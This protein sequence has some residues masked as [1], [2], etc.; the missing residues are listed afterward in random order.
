MKGVEDRLKKVLFSVTKEYIRTRRPV[1][2]K[3]VLEVTNLDWSG[4]TIR[5]DMRKLE[6]LGYLYQPHTSAGRIPTD[7]ALRFYLNEILKIRVERLETGFDIDLNPSF[8][9]GDLNTILDVLARILSKA[10]SG[11][12]VMTRPKLSNLRI[13]GIYI[14]PIT[15]DFAV[16]SAVTELGLSSVV[17]VRTGEMNLEAFERLLR[18]FSGKT[19]G[20]VIEALRTFETQ[21]EDLTDA[22]RTMSNVFKLLTI[23]E[24][25]IVRG[26]TE[27]LRE[28][29]GHEL[30]GVLRV[31]EDQGAV[32]ELAR[33]AE[34]GLKVFV[35]SENTL[36]V[37][38][39]FAVFVA[40]YRKASERVGS[41][42]LI[43][44]KFIPYERVYP[45]VE[46]VS[47]RLTEYLT[48]ASRGVM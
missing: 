21:N 5:N 27:L 28:F 31:V 39:Q 42:I 45:M 47:N 12:V 24:G 32:E 1:S 15:H 13:M 43:T 40:P 34:D 3:R 18:L 22:I 37:F 36:E 46:F 11:L 25:P 10:V 26:V 33:E 2:S 19:F 4:A 44:S 30:E 16:V 17:P 48:V 9:I 23:G 14:T 8:P 41:V 35:G 6:E 20:E 7:K 29:Q 38:K